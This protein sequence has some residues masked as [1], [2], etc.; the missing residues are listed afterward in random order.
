M[1]IEDLDIFICS[2]NLNWRIM[3]SQKNHKFYEFKMNIL[4]NIKATQN[5][6]EPI[7]YCFQEASNYQDIIKLFDSKNYD[8]DVGKSGYEQILTIWNKNI[9]KKKLIINSEFCDGRPF[10]IIVFNDKRYKNNFMLINVHAS[11]D[12]NTFKTIFQPIQNIIKA[13][14][15]VYNKLIEFDIKRIVICGDFNRNIND[16]L[17]DDIKKILHLKIGR[18]KFYFNYKSNDNKTCCSLSGYGYAKNYDHV[19]DSY[20]E[21]IFTLPLNKKNW[22]ETK[23]SDH[24]MILSVVKNFI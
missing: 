9:L 19:I 4:K 20:N 23:S 8:T 14:K 1:K 16:D 2:Y 24:I 13:N 18:K 11:H 7:I 21:P 3:E 22:Y 10:T 6:Y 17:K 12:H 5:I 15:I